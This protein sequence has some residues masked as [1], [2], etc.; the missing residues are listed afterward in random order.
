MA[1]PMTIGALVASTLATAAPAVM[2]T[3]AGQAAKDAYKALKAQLLPFASAEVDALEATP[4]SKNAQLAVAEVIDER[5]EPEQQALRTVAEQLIAKLKDSAPATGIDISRLSALERHLRATGL[6]RSLGADIGEFEIGGVSGKNPAPPLEAQAGDAKLRA[7]LGRIGTSFL[8][9]NAPEQ[10]TGLVVVAAIVLTAGV[11][12]WGTKSFR[13]D[14]SAGVER[15]AGARQ[16]QLRLLASQAAGG[17]A[18]AVKANADLRDMLRSNVSKINDV[19]AEQLPK[20]VQ[21]IVADLQKPAARPAD[22]AG[23]VQRA[24]ER[25]QNQVGEL[26]FVEAATTLDEAISATETERANSEDKARHA[27]ALSAER[28]R[29]AG[30]QLRYREAAKF[31][32]KAAEA[33]GFDPELSWTY[34]L[35]SAQALYDQGDAFADNG[36]LSESIRTYRS[37]FSLAPRDRAPL[38]WAGTQNNL[39]L[40]LA[41]LGERESGTTTLREAVAAFHEALKV[42]TRER[43]PL[44]W[45]MTQNNLG[46]ALEKLGER[47]QARAT[48]Q[49]AAGAYRAALKEFTRERVPF[50]WAMTQN[51]LGNVLR[52]LGEQERGQ[53]TLQQAAAAYRD[54]LKVLTPERIPPLDWATTQ[55]NLGNALLALGERETGAAALQEA[56]GAYREALKERTRE[57]APLLWAKTQ[58]NLGDALRA[59]GERETGAAALQEAVAAYREALKEYTRER[60]PREWAMTQND[61]GNA[62]EALGKRESGTATLQQAVAAHREA[63]KVYTRE[64]APLLWAT[65]QNDLGNALRALG[66]R[67]SGATPL[68]EA[69]AA[70]GEALKERPRG[71]HRFDWATSCGN[72]AV[73]MMRLAERTK[74]AATAKAAISQL[75]AA[76]DT[77]QADG[78]A[79][80]ADYYQ[81]RLLEARAVSDKFGAR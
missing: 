52:A 38:N 13:R 16:E 6:A 12:L 81:A 58:D 33:T 72:Q 69:V 46:N 40:A 22:F 65:A 79:S 34:D 54:A 80:E 76:Y 32:A 14:R 37:A 47:E 39:G 62:L 55:N 43:V 48:L 45:A 74:D 70:Y 18:P 5:S 31:Y 75:S 25:A 73:A 17:G 60:R 1:G 9:A 49:D 41:K 44:D 66:E 67:E 19:S 11:G 68:R 3:A 8:G 77:M 59:L 57:R 53:A 61:L 27:A 15:S 4:A 78:H 50:Q 36:A 10:V 26:K 35:A 64:G 30:L 23:P 7:L 56:V 20:V 24:L 71:Q 28:G 42:L 63:L 2:K 29:V 51:N 21:R